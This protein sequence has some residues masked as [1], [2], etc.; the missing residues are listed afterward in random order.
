MIELRF[1]INPGIIPKVLLEKSYFAGWGRTPRPTRALVEGNELL[2]RSHIK[3]SGTLHVLRPHDKLGLV[4]ESTDSLLSRSK[5]YYLIRE[6]GRGALGCLQKKIF[7]WQMLGFRVSPEIRSQVEEVS[8]RYSKAVVADQENP[9][10]E[11]ELLQCLDVF[12]QITL[13]AA[14]LFTE[15][16]IA[17]RTRNN[18]KLPVFFGVGTRNHSFDTP[19]EFDL[20]AQFLRKAFHAVQP[21]PTWRELEPQPDVFRWDLLERRISIPARFG[22]KIIMGPL[23]CFDTATFPAWLATRLGEEG[24]FESRATRFVNAVA[25]RF[26]SQ[27]DYWI[28]AN[29]FNSCFVKELPIPRTITLIRLLAQQL[30][31]RGLEKQILV[32]IDRPWGEYALVSVPEY[33]Q[34]QIAESL[35]SCHE[36]DAFLMEL[37]FG[38]SDQSTYPRDPMTV[39]NMI[40]QWS[41]LGKKVYVSLSVPSGV[42]SDPN[43]PDRAVAPELQWS[44]GLQQYWTEALISTLMG[45]RMVQGI[46]WTSLQDEEESLDDTKSLDILQSPYSGLIDSSNVVKL[47]FKQFVAAKINLVK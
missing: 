24:V 1:R 5:P 13:D 47:A 39:S 33:D 8:R 43:D 17:W 16:S 45:K 10:I 36:I 40:D 25:E 27:A 20:Y 38:L 15:Q 6:L 28:L 41:F 30:R 23:L 2:I 3:G 14:K 22:F 19:Y 11:H 12:S 46:F 7:E 4:V 32:G 26:G 31:S 44:E 35:M 9:A 18:E 37:N 29:R 34:V 42:S 21:M